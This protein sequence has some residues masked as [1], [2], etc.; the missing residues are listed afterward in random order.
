MIGR[1]LPPAGS[2]TLIR[3]SRRSIANSGTAAFC[4][5]G[6]RQTSFLL[7][8]V[9]DRIVGNES[10]TAIVIRSRS[11]DR[12]GRVAPPA[13][14]PS[15]ATG[16]VKRR[17]NQLHRARVLEVRIQ[18]PPAESQVRTCLSREFAFLRREAA[19][20]R[21]CACWGERR[22]RQRRTRSSNIA[23]MSGSVSVGR[24]SSTALSPMRFATVGAPLSRCAPL[25]IQQ[26]CCKRSRSEPCIPPGAILTKSVSERVS[27]LI[28]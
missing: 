22:G 10:I 1:G 16:R 24:Y 23:L 3:P 25:G 18:S 4:Y 15:Q 14:D 6:R 2:I 19:V 27:R 5:S 12:G 20:S 26:Y 7:L 9:A 28:L 21:G 8:S 13:A 11:A 17:D